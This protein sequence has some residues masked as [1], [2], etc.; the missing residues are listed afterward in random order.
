MRNIPYFTNSSI[1][2]TDEIIIVLPGWRGK[3]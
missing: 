1:Q 2:V 3:G